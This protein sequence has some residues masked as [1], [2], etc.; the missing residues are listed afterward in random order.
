MK[1]ALDV[2]RRLSGEQRDEMIEC[3]DQDLDPADPTRTR[4]FV[5]E[6]VACTATVLN[7]GWT[8]VYRWEVE[9]EI[10]RRLQFGKALILYDLLPPVSAIDTGFAFR[11]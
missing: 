9:L 2:I 7:N 8:A 3:L 11:P 1:A 5:V 10:F 6:G 4:N